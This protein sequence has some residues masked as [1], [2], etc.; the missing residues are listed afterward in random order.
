LDPLPAGGGEYLY[1]FATSQ[2]ADV[3][4]VAETIFAG[5]GVER[6]AVRGPLHCRPGPATR[7]LQGLLFE[8]NS[9]LETG[10]KL[11]G[12]V[13][14]SILTANPGR[15]KDSHYGTQPL[16]SRDPFAFRQA[17]EKRNRNTSIPSVVLGELLRLEE[18]EV[19]DSICDGTN[20]KGIDGIYV[21]S[22]AKQVD[23]FQVTLLKAADKRKAM[24]S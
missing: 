17:Y 18:L 11:K 23:F 3:I 16:V 19:Q 4:S 20:D 22:P 12:G 15:H 14:I 21:N 9:N 7:I 10:A 1:I 8:G 13:L 6:C 24:R 2:L 5:L